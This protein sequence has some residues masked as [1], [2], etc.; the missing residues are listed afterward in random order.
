[1]RAGQG[2]KALDSKDRPK[3]VRPVGMVATV[4]ALVFVLAGCGGPTDPRLMN[5]RSTGQG[6]D[7]FSILPPKALELPEDL[8]ALPDPTPGGENL[9]DQRPFGFTEIT[10]PGNIVLVGVKRP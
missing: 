2:A 7:E 1:M 10:F 8:T 3:G 4:T 9:T 6:P 5:L